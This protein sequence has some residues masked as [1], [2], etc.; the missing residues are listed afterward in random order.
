MSHN[1]GMAR[2][3]RQAVQMH[4]GAPLDADPNGNRA[5]RRAAAKR[6]IKAQAKPDVA[7]DLDDIPPN[8]GSAT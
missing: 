3:Q 1:R 2:P 6:G 8:A 5:Q 4:N 7:A